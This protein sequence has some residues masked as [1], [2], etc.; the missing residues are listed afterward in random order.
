M[1][2]QVFLGKVEACLELSVSK[3]DFM[4]K[5]MQVTGLTCQG[6]HSLNTTH[7]CFTMLEAGKSK[8]QVL[9]EM[10]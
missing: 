1:A 9:K 8:E 2:N 4:E 3:D 5:V 7:V 6:F 10:F